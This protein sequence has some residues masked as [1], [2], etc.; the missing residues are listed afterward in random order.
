[1][2]PL[3]SAKQGDYD[4]QAKAIMII[5]ELKKPAIICFL[6]L[7]LSAL[8]ASAGWSGEIRQPLPR[9][10]ILAVGGTI[11]GTGQSSTQTTEYK[12]G[13]LDIASLIKSVPDLDKLA[14]ISGEQVANIDSAHITNDILLKLAQKVDAVLENGKADAVV[15]THGTDTMEETAYFLNL[16]VKSSKPVVLTGSMRPATAISADGP[17]NL[18]N[19]VVLAASPEAR[20]KGVL[21]ALNERIHGAR[22]VTKMHTTNVDAFR[23][24]EFGCLG[25]VLNGKAY[26]F[27]TT[28]KR[29]T[30]DSEFRLRGLKMLPR[31][32]ILYGH[33]NDSGDLVDAA[34][35]AGAKGI[36]HA[37]VGDGGVYPAT[38]EALKEARKKGVIIV[39]SSRVGSGF[40]APDSDDEKDGIVTSNT[41]NPQ[42]ARILLILA[43][44]RTTDMKEIQR[45]FNEY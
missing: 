9:I 4:K 12:A 14:L 16:T 45:M 10:A 2:S 32:D 29:H 20:G 28:T 19:A 42:K 8:L 31:V 24:P 23:S 6:S 22:D 26:F 13:V 36:I 43:L 17:L 7:V 44:T 38:Y 15:I 35:R 1:M 11:A 25:Y 21:V 27:K 40:V 41:L 30:V 5:R 39:R 37:G 18:Y 3:F 33:G 34:V